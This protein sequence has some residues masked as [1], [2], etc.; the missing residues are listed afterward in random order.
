MLRGNE[1]VNKLKKIRSFLDFGVPLN[2]IFLTSYFPDFRGPDRCKRRKNGRILQKTAEFLGSAE[3]W[4]HV[5]DGRGEREARPSL[6]H[7]LGRSVQRIQPRPSIQPIIK[8]IFSPRLFQG[9]QYLDSV[10]T[11]IPLPKFCEY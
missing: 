3:E 9:C 8:F 2:Y 6:L 5:S 4:H 7:S 10:N 11:E 1:I